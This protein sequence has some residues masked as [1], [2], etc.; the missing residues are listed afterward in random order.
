[1]TNIVYH[2][3]SGI[4]VPYSICAEIKET[5]N[6]WADKSRHRKNTTAVM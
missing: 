6:I 5:D 2:I 3:L 1:M 4:V